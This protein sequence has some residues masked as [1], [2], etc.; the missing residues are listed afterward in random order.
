MLLPIY[1]DQAGLLVKT[2][3]WGPDRINLLSCLWNQWRER[4]S[5]KK[6]TE[7]SIRTELTRKQV[8]CLCHCP[9][10]VSIRAADTMMREVMQQ[11]MEMF[12]TLS[13]GGR[14]TPTFCLE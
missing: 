4:L 9:T 3:V 12:I 8:A 5:R 11:E 14:E 1:C 6:K 13:Q 10:T 2:E 7:I